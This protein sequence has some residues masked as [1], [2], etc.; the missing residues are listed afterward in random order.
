MKCE[1]DRV[2]STCSICKPELVYRAYKHKARQRNLAFDL[3]QE[4]FEQ[5][6]QQRCVFCGAYGPLG[7]D[8]RDN[9][10]GYVLWNVQPCCGPCNFLK[11]AMSQYVFLDQV[12]KI[13]RYQEELQK[14]RATPV[15]E[16]A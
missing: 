14:R 11:R 13:C 10:I 7:L 6:L 3:T 1:H 5:L 9:G 12:R 16:A 4:Q 2:R 15:S 8:R